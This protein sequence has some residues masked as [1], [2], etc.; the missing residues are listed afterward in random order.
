[1]SADCPHDGPPSGETNVRQGASRDD[2]TT[3]DNYIIRYNDMFKG[4]SRFYLDN[5]ITP[6]MPRAD[7]AHTEI[8]S[9]IAAVRA[10]AE[11]QVAGRGEAS[12]SVRSRLFLAS[13]I[14]ED[15]R[16][17]RRTAVS[18]EDDIPG[19]S[20]RFAL[21]RS[22]SYDR[23]IAAADDMITAV[24]ENQA[25]FTEAGIPPEFLTTL[26][27]LITEFHSAGGEKLGG[28]NLQVMSTAALRIKIKQGLKA[29]RRL[30]ACV[31]NHFRD[32]PA[33]LA[34]WKSARHIN[35][36]PTRSDADEP[37]AAPTTAPGASNG[38]PSPAA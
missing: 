22:N 25:A 5:T 26:D 3:M 38:A 24:G 28:G 35:R 11:S 1:M 15:L 16:E 33:V 34:A 23:M 6:A 2:Q 20:G 29:V 19:I 14:R 32:N 10:K 4:A 9:V 18:L 27:G 31:R 30:D 8:V 7:A 17:I 13:E 36:A 21:P 37:A 12:H